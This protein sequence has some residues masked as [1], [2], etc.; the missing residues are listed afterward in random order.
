MHLFLCPL[1]NEI[2]ALEMVSYPDIR[3]DREDL[4]D[5]SIQLGITFC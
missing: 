4:L 3:A 5:R 2:G 1:Y